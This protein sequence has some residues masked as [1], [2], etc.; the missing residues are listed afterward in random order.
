MQGGK[1]TIVPPGYIRS[2]IPIPN[3]F[4]CCLGNEFESL[5]RFASIACFFADP[6]P[7]N[8]SFALF[9]FL[10]CVQQFLITPLQFFFS[11]ALSELSVM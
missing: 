8:C 5:Q 11:L 2:S 3:G 7:P 9:Q 1:M 6:C 4:F 10:M